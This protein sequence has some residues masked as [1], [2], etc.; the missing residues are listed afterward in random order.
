VECAPHALPQKNLREYAARRGI[1]AERLFFATR[2]PQDEHIARLRAADLALDVLPYGSHT[3]G[4]DA[5][6]AGVPMLTCRGDA[7]AGRVG[8]SLL[9]A[10]GLD[11]LITE[12]LAA[13]RA[14][15]IAL[16]ADPGRLAAY[17]DYWIGGH[18]C[19]FSIRKVSRGI[20][21]CVGRSATRRRSGAR[22]G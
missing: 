22:S 7:F 11:E 5:L 6:W 1:G 20:G 17:R 12:D 10:T 18:V 19:R 9:H 14:A 3:T 2:V 15:L 16:A 13:Y 8:A 21:R 4:V